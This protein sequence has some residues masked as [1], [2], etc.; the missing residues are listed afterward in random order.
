M[1]RRLRRLRCMQ[2][3]LQL[4]HRVVGL[5]GRR[6]NWWQRLWIRRKILRLNC[7]RVSIGS[8]LPRQTNRTHQI[9]PE[10]LPNL[11]NRPSQITQLRSGI[12]ALLQLTLQST[13][14]MVKREPAL[15]AAWQSHFP[16]RTPKLWL[17]WWSLRILE[18]KHGRDIY[19]EGE[20]DD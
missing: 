10:R 19:G 12:P 4:H 13:Q 18:S 3:R 7:Y 17:H 5:R 6:S 15:R 1:V 16:T 2:L 20:R 11:P 14:N 9:P 8:P